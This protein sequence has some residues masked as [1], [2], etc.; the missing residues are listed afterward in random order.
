MKKEL[1]KRTTQLLAIAVVVLL[2]A[3]LGAYW[4]DFVGAKTGP[5]GPPG[6][7]GAVGA[8]GPMGPAGTTPVQPT[9]PNAPTSGGPTITHGEVP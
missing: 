4:M 6:E 3:L 8:Q 9:T 5:P 7:R 2:L 1:H